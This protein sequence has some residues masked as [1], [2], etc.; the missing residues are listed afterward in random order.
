L[1]NDQY[2]MSAINFILDHQINGDG[3]GKFNVL[4]LPVAKIDLH[5]RLHE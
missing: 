2:E 3:T 5:Q 4:S 1:K